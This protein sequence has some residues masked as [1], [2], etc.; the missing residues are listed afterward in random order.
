ML[1]IADS[2]RNDSSHFNFK[3]SVKIGTNSEQLT[4]R[5]SA[6][7]DFCFFSSNFFGFSLATGFG[8]IGF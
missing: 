2:S 4:S 1:V 5:Q 7:F 8:G 6:S 3:L